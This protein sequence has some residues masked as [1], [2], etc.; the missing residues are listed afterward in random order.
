MT[1]VEYLHSLGVLGPDVSLA[2]CVWVTEQDLEILKDSGVKIVHCPSS[3]MRLGSGTMSLA[4]CATAGIPVAIGTDSMTLS[5]NQDLLGE[6]RLA[7]YMSSVRPS[8]GVAESD[9]FSARQSLA[10]ATSV[11]GQA[12]LTKERVGV[13]AKGWKAD[14]ILLD[15]HR[16]LR[17]HT[18]DLP[19]V[20]P[21]ILFQRAGRQSMRSVIIGGQIRLKDGT[22]PGIDTDALSERIADS[23]AA[24]AKRHTGVRRRT[25]EAIRKQVHG[26]LQRLGAD[27]E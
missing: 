23:A 1:E 9:G 13:I 10:M 18:V 25:Y 22:F 3:N 27:P 26:Y 5:E 11:G 7:V 16:L 15:A 8:T 24:G 4:A 21:E 12:T 20:L 17:P 6:L 2:H 14:L 19:D